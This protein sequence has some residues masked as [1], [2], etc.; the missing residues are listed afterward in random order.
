MENEP[1][2][3][4]EAMQVDLYSIT[5]YAMRNKYKN[6]DKLSRGQ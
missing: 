6:K 3:T 1:V 5:F 2:K 4:D